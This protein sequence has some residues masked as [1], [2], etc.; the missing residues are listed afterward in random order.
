MMID[1]T[2][3]FDAVD[4][5]GATTVFGRMFQHPI[6]LRKTG[7]HLAEIQRI[8]K[9]PGTAAEMAEAWQQLQVGIGPAFLVEL[10]GSGEFREVCPT[11]NGTPTPPPMDDVLTVWTDKDGK[12]V[13][14]QD[15]ATHYLF[16]VE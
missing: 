15:K 14:A 6:N 16:V 13:V 4:W 2:D 3:D 5:L 10:F 7:Q 9:Q 11:P 8:A 1:F 12:R